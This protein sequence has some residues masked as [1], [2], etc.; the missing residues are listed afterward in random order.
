M[1]PCPPRP[2]AAPTL[3]T[4]R[5]EAGEPLGSDG[6]CPQPLALSWA[7]GL[8]VPIAREGFPGWAF[9]PLAPQTEEGCLLRVQGVAPAGGVAGRPRTRDGR[10]RPDGPVPSSSAQNSP[11]VCRGPE[12]GVALWMCQ[13]LAPAVSPGGDRG[14]RSFSDSQAGAV[15][16][17]SLVFLFGFR[18]RAEQI[19]K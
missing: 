7:L 17:G 11:C 8:G 9:G 16:L 2:R 15:P 18:L 4:C 1:L 6:S 13:Q 12:Q 10:W 3:C 14:G 5:S 19:P